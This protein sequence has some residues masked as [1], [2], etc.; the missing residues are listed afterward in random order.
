MNYYQV[1]GWSVHGSSG[2]LGPLYCDPKGAAFFLDVESGVFL[3]F[4]RAKMK[5]CLDFFLRGK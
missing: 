5:I 4:N 3:K 1:V 2:V